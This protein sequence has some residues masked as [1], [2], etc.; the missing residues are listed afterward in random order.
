M[1]SAFLFNQS[2]RWT[3]CHSLTASA[4]G[5]A[6]PPALSL[7]PCAS[8]PRFERRDENPMTRK[9]R[10]TCGFPRSAP[11]A[12]LCVTAGTRGRGTDGGGPHPSAAVLP[13]AVQTSG[14]SAPLQDSQ[15]LR[16][17]PR[18]TPAPTSF[19]PGHQLLPQAGVP[20]PVRA[21]PVLWWLLKLFSRPTT[22]GA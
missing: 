17:A 12:G 20:A 8:F 16:G 19:P 15:A 4:A 14:P 1:W 3:A 9:V 22:G 2:C 13:Q 21:I 18:P 11:P 7:Q 10:Q 5:L 6:E